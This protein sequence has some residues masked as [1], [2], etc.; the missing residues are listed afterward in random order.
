VNHAAVDAPRA[1]RWQRPYL[2]LGLFA[3]TN[4]R[5]EL[6]EQPHDVAAAHPG[7]R[8]Q[9][10]LIPAPKGATL[11]NV[12]RLVA[13]V[14][15]T[16]AILAALGGIGLVAYAVADPQ[17]PKQPGDLE[18]D[19]PWSVASDSVCVDSERF[20]RHPVDYQLSRDLSGI[21]LL[22]VTSLVLA[23]IAWGLFRGRR[24]NTAT[25]LTSHGS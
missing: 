19:N 25:A 15:A 24:T 12:R 22:A 7:H 9:A 13:V 11:P 21:L 5:G 10:V 23:A 8:Q 17:P 6:P 4:L 18:C 1:C 3:T 14:V 20:I 2:S 16:L